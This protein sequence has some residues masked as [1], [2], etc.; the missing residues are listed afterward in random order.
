MK[1]GWNHRRRFWT[2]ALLPGFALLAGGCALLR[3]GAD[4][5]RFYLLTAAPPALTEETT[6]PGIEVTLGRVEVPRFLESPAMA[7]RVDSHE[8]RFAGGHHWAEP[9]DRAV[10][11]VLR[12]WLEASPAVGRVVGY[13]A[14]SAKTGAPEVRVS[15]IRAEGVA[16]PEEPPRAEF[17]AAWELFQG[18][19][20]TGRRGRVERVD[21]PWDG[22]S[23]GQLAASLSE[24]VETLAR[25]I[26]LALEEWE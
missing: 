16:L 11:R 25:A 23:H 13:P 19:E 9:L 14:R 20:S 15:L 8:L 17:E 7:V 22:V 10:N 1:K 18:G 21:L 3:P 5:T 4:T 2:R 24:G 6:A 26:S 12:D